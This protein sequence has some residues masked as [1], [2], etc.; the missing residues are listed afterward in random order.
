MSAPAA[1]RP[2]INRTRPSG[3][4]ARKCATS[5]V[6]T[7]T[8]LGNLI[9]KSMFVPSVSSLAGIVL[10]RSVQRWSRGWRKGTPGARS[11]QLGVVRPLRQFI[12]PARQPGE[13][14]GELEVDDLSGL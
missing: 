8:S 9:G 14:L 13:L 6:M 4:S 12:S 11:L 5:S 7:S 1:N 10:E 3:D 2:A